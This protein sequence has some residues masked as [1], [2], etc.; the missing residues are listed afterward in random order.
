MTIRNVELFSNVLSDFLDLIQVA[1]QSKAAL[2]SADDFVDT[3]K[4]PPLKQVY[5]P[6]EVFS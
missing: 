6:I 1:F 4:G 3:L 5:L 2:I